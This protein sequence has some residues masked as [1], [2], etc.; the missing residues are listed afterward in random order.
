MSR[1]LQRN[2]DTSLSSLSVPSY[3]PLCRQDWNWVST[4]SMSTVSTN[5]GCIR[6]LVLPKNEMEARTVV[7]LLVLPIATLG[8]HRESFCEKEGVN[9]L[10]ITD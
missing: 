9:R 4:F 3:D 10:P 5:Y 2:L 7:T 8:A 1:R 6:L